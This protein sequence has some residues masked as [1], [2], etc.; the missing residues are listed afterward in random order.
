ME[1]KFKT[2][3]LL[4]FSFLLL[5]ISFLFIELYFR[6]NLHLMDKCNSKQ[7]GYIRQN[8]FFTEAYELSLWEEQWRSYKK[9]VELNKIMMNEK[10]YVRMNNYGFR[11]H[12]IHMPKPK[13]VYR[14]ICIGGSTTVEGVTN[15]KT[16]P[17]ILERYLR[18]YFKTDTI[19]VVNCGI[20]GLDSET[21]KMKICE[22]IQLEPDLFI[23]YNAVNDIFWKMFKP[24]RQTKKPLW[25]RILSKSIF[26][27]KVLIRFLI[28][29]D[30]YVINFFETFTIPNLEVIYQE[31]SKSNKEIIFCTFIAPDVSKLNN[32]EVSYFEYTIRNF[33]RGGFLPLKDYCRYVSIYNDRLKKMCKE[34]N[35]KCIPLG[36]NFH[37]GIDNF[38]DIAHLTSK[39][40]KKKAG[41]IFYYL[42]DMGIR[43]TDYGY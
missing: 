6:I 30:K 1:N 35:I 29:P 39:G 18:D 20:S 40:I 33:W 27:Q 10:L 17:A 9:N 23:E 19:E 16:Y 11:S 43:R 38:S 15:E 25:K 32:K 14:I 4:F 8:P 42:K 21:E 36:E 7:F 26:M 13:N 31:V 34:K 22:F 37:G 24:W 28:P 41:I 3:S 12:D 5:I 2:C